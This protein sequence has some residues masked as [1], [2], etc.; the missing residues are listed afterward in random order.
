MVN[1]Y[2][3]IVKSVPSNHESVLDG[4]TAYY[5]DIYQ[6]M[7]FTYIS[8]SIAQQCSDQLAHYVQYIYM[9]RRR[10]KPHWTLLFIY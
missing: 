4:R 3:Y 9:S 5:S 2:I 7:Q 10:I 6:I 8:Y 1:R